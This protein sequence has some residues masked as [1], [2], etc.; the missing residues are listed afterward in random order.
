[1]FREPERHAQPDPPVVRRLRLRGER[2]RQPG[3]A[4]R[5]PGRLE[6]LLVLHAD[7]LEPVRD[8]ILGD[9]AEHDPSASARHSLRKVG[10]G[11]GH[12]DEDR[13]AGRLLERL[14]EGVGRFV[15][16]Q[17]AFLEQEHLAGGLH[18]SE[19]GETNRPAGL[20][21]RD[22]LPA[23][24]LDHGYVRMGALEDTPGTCVVATAEERCGKS[25]GR[26]SLAG[27]R[28][29]DEE[30]GLRRGRSLR[31]QQ[32]EHGL[33]ANEIGEHVYVCGHRSS[34]PSMTLPTTT[35]SGPSAAT[36][37][38]RSGSRAASSSNVAA[39]RLWKA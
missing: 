33:M 14:Q 27:V 22:R 13:R 3:P 34:I 10:I 6:G 9:P 35:S 39:T 31:S 28:G 12:E 21:D 15:V 32:I 24:R 1:M 17:P 26:R 36:T 19:A 23:L 7:G 11:F 20:I 37:R 38:N 25:P 29:T 18:R 16:E 30:I 2:T 4:R 8:L 5:D